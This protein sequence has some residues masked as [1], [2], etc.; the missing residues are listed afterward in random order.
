MSLLGI[1][2]NENELFYTCRPDP[3]APPRFLP[4]VMDLELPPIGEEAGPNRR[5]SIPVLLNSFFQNRTTEP[6]EKIQEKSQI[7]SRYFNRVVD[8]INEHPDSGVLLLEPVDRCCLVGPPCAISVQL[9]ELEEALAPVAVEVR[10]ASYEVVVLAGIQGR[11]EAEQPFVLCSGDEELVLSSASSYET[12]QHTSR[13]G[14]LYRHRQLGSEAVEAA[15]RG[16]LMETLHRRSSSGLSEAK[17]DPE[18]LS[19]LTFSWTRDL[20]A[21]KGQLHGEVPLTGKKHSENGAGSLVGI[22]IDETECEEILAPIRRRIRQ[23]VTS[24]SQA[25]KDPDH[26]YAVLAGSLPL[27]SLFGPTILDALLEAGLKVTPATPDHPSESTSPTPT[28]TA[29]LGVHL[30]VRSVP[31]LPYDCG[32]LLRQPGENHGLGTL[33]LTRPTRIG[34][35]RTSDPLELHLGTDD[36]L[37]VAFYVRRVDFSTGKIKLEVMKSHQFVARRDENRLTRVRVKMRVER[38]ETTPG[39][40]LTISI[41]LENLEN[42]Q[43]V[44]F[45]NLRLRGEVELDR[46]PFRNPDQIAGL[47]W[48]SRIQEIVD[49]LEDQRREYPISA[50]FNTMTSGPP[51]A[52]VPRKDYAQVLLQAL[53]PTSG[54]WAEA[55]AT[56]GSSEFVAS[57]PAQEIQDTARR[58][59]FTAMHEQAALLSRAGNQAQ[60]WSRT[61]PLTQPPPNETNCPERF[62]NAISATVADS[63]DEE[64]LTAQAKSLMN[65]YRHT[66][67]RPVDLNIDW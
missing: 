46:P 9:Q 28:E 20:M 30:C 59:L 43:T 2:W 67:A 25:L 37:E 26:E 58:L 32:V 7:L 27:S 47:S 24:A 31:L 33:V 17:V 22:L 4:E 18:A 10:V 52:R 54:A 35:S 60:V 23:F 57:S 15:L 38:D 61:Y 8:T 29:A 3:E 21:G 14:R 11:L 12:L 1:S 63:E 66:T 6:R 39:S 13:K 42:D 64:A 36:L 65:A 56:L 50:W 41:D 53:E 62:F 55:Q 48:K 19:K 5:L 40:G 44:S 49:G 16:H 34:E 45:E 51:P